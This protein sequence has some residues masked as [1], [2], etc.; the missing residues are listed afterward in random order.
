MFVAQRQS[1]WPLPA[2]SHRQCHRPVDNRDEK[3]QGLRSRSRRPP[4]R[5][6]SRRQCPRPPLLKDNC[7]CKD[8]IG[9]SILAICNC[10]GNLRRRDQIVC[11]CGEHGKVRF[12]S[13]TFIVQVVLLPLG[14]CAV[15]TRVENVCAPTVATSCVAFVSGA[16]LIHPTLV[17]AATVHLRCALALRAALRARA[18]LSRQAALFN[19]GV[20]LHAHAFLQHVL[21]CALAT[22]LN[23]ATLRL[24][25]RSALRL[26]AVLRQAA[27]FDARVHLHACGLLHVF[28]DS[29]ATLLCAA[30]LC[31][32][33]ILRLRATQRMRAAPRLRAALMQAVILDANILLHTLLRVPRRPL[34]RVA[35]RSSQARV[36]GE[37]PRPC[38][39]GHLFPPWGVAHIPRLQPPILRAR[40][41]KVLQRPQ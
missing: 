13:I 4:S 17:R 11:V 30:A 21:A 25:L 28:A 15:C 32:R 20:Q 1:P 29:H 2:E 7:D 26:R 5:P 6:N 16:F 40:L 24:R 33:A 10:L 36:A 9:R 38:G 39:R 41:Q 14:Q 12:V 37:R 34:G 18:A 23:A 35:R 8:T 27:L 3:G 22:L 31:L 19:A